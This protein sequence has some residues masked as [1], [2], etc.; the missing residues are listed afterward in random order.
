[1]KAKVRSTALKPCARNPGARASLARSGRVGGGAAPAA[2][3]GKVASGPSLGV[4]RRSFQGAPVRGSRVR[5][6]YAGTNGAAGEGLLLSKAEVPAFIPREDFLQ[7]LYQWAEI[8]I[9][10]QSR[11]QFGYSMVVERVEPDDTHLGGFRVQVGTETT[12]DIVMDAE[13]TEKYEF[14]GRGQDGFPEPKGKKEIV[15]GKF[16]EIRKIDSNKVSEQAKSAIKELIS[17]VMKAFDMY[18]AFG[19]VFCDDTT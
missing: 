8:S 12:I 1:M 15:K 9:G 11:S 17:A 5:I 3:L 7:Q 6:A 13:E 2:V 14:V 18:Y 19:S 10:Q 16:L 4:A